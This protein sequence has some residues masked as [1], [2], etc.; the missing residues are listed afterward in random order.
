[1]TIALSD[2]TITVNNEPIAIVP[3]SFKFTEGKGEQTYRAASAGGGSV[4]PVYSN[5]V[6]SLFSSFG[7]EL[8]NTIGDIE[9]A[10]Q[11]KSNRDQNVVGMT[12]KTPDGK[13]ISRTFAR[14]A[15]LN[16]YEVQL[17]SDT[18]FSL[19]FKSKPAV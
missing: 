16:D 9:S 4:E 19:E 2:V 14:A 7:F 13:T 17:G 15:I 8:Y 18:T 12:G 5:D 11:W 6:T 1:M 10:R 3:N